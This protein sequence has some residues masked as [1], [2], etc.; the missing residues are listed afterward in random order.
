MHTELVRFA[1]TRLRG[2]VVEALGGILV[3]LELRPDAVLL[4]GAADAGGELALKVGF[5]LGQ[6]DGLPFGNGELL[7]CRLQQEVNGPLPPAGKGGV[8]H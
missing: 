4:R 5:S 8:V 7:G 6:G 1:E 3:L 2:E